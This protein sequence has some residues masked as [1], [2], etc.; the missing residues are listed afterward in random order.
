MEHQIA[1]PVA[2]V[3]AELNVQQGQQVE[4]GAVLAVIT[5]E[6]AAEHGAATAA[7]SAEESTE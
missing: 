2:G 1:A 3:V 4:R 6:P 5:A 7:V